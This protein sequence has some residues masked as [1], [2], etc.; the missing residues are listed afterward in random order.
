MKSL[1]FSTGLGLEVKVGH[2]IG[3]GKLD[4]MFHF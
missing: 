4:A 2:F 1:N 3:S